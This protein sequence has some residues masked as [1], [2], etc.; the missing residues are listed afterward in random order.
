MNRKTMNAWAMATLL[1]SMLL[2][3]ATGRADAA[4]TGLI[5]IPTADVVPPGQYGAEFQMNGE[6]AARTID[7]RIINSEFG[8]APR[9]EAGLDLDVSDDADG[10]ALLNAKYLITPSNAH[11]PAVA[12]GLFSLGPRLKSSGYVVATQ[13]FR[14]F[15]AHGGFMRIDDRD[16]WF[17]GADAPITKRVTLMTDFISGSDN[18]SSVG[19]NF[20]MGERYC[21]LAGVLFPNQH[22]QPTQFNLHLCLS[23]SYHRHS[24]AGE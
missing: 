11:R 6:L 23:G 3:A 22:G 20:A 16:R 12:T 1:A 21:I 24:K 9:V 7:G 13:P 17:I 14:G 19:I 8:L 18:F 2:P 10:R 5:A 4:F 15:R